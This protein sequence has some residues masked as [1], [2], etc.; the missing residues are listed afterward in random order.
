MRRHTLL[1]PLVLGTLAAPR[2]GAAQQPGLVVLNKSEATASI[3]SLADGRTVATMPVGDGPHEIAVSP[4]GRWAMASN[5]GG[6]TPGHSLTLLDL[7]ARTAVRTI[8][9]GEYKRPHG[10]AWLPDG[11]RVVVTSELAQ[12]VFVVEAATGKIEKAIST[13]VGGT[14]LLVLSKDGKR[15]WTSNIFSGSNSL[16]DLEKGVLVKTA[17]NGK[18]PEAIDLSP[19]GRELWT[20]DRPLNRITILDANTLDSI[21]AWPSGQFPNRLHFTPDGQTVLQSNAQSSTVGVYDAKSR[22]LLGN[23]EFPYDEALGKPT[24]LTQFGRSA[25]PLGILIAPDG[26]RAWVALA[27]HDRLAEVDIATRKVV[28]TITAGREPDG[29]AYVPDIGAG[30]P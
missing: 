26:K 27:A 1:L 2:A 21:A 3:I 30:K 18:G 28:R 17:P 16:L 4:D 5:Y 13:G 11:K 15:V 22:K 7:R 6:T 14:H 8:E 25:T 20:A 23:I 24:V 12:A 10:I 9:L 29:M 19:D